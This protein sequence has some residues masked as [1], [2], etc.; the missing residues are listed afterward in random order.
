M[1]DV[2]GHEPLAARVLQHHGDEYGDALDGL[3]GVSLAPVV[4]CVRHVDVYLL[5]MFRLQVGEVDAAY[6]AV[7]HAKVDLVVVVSRLGDLAGRELRVDDMLGVALEGPA[8]A[9]LRAVLGEL[10]GPLLGLGVGALETLGLVLLLAGRVA[11]V[12]D[13][14]APFAAALLLALLEL[15]D[16]VVL[17]HGVKSNLRV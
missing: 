1:R 8:A 17:G 9:Q 5:D 11:A 2:G 13:V 12:L 6:G 10:L 14:D 7:G 16:N 3:G 15:G 4:D